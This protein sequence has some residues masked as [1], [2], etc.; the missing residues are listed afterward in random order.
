[1]SNDEVWSDAEYAALQSRVA[2][3]EDAI[4]GLLSVYAPTAR[5][6]LAKEK[7]LAVL[8]SQSAKDSKP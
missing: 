5:N 8:A 1:M 4:R 7:A 2:D 6:R 3:L